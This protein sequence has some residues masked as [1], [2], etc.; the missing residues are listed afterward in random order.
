MEGG[1]GS[2][3]GSRRWKPTMEQ[4]AILESMLESM[5]RKG[6]RSPKVQEIE[7]ITERLQKFGR[8]EGKN[9]FY[10]FQN[11]NARERE[12][13]RKQKTSHLLLSGAQTGMRFIY[14]LSFFQKK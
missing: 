14:Y 3:S 4:K 8:V 1:S 6:I 7:S 11:V 12:M 10:W 2:G 9:V 13:H 5:H